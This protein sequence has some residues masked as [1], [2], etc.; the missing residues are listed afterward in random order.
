MSLVIYVSHI[1]AKLQTPNTLRARKILVVDADMRDLDSIKQ[2]TG[3]RGWVPAWFVGKVNGD[4]QPNSAATPT[5]PVILSGPGKD[6]K[7][8]KEG[9]GD[10]G[11][12]AGHEDVGDGGV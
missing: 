7:E 6:G 3:E 2:D 8:S 5:G 4:S 9:Q 10:G 11:L 1:S 12:E